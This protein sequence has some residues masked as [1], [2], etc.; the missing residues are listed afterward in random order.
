MHVI[1]VLLAFT[2]CS[3]FKK[4]LQTALQVTIKCSCDPVV[5]KSDLTP[6]RGVM[7]A[8]ETIRVATTAC[9]CLDI[10]RVF[11][12]NGFDGVKELLRCS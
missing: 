6:F 9:V 7:E 4:D 11:A 5:D 8:L 2:R 12:V 10:G 1:R 3:G